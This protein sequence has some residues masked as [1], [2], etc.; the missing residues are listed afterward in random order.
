MLALS[1]SNELKQKVAGLPTEA[2]ISP[3]AD[4]LRRP[5]HWLF[6]FFSFA[7]W[8]AI[9]IGLVLLA[10]EREAPLPI[11]IGMLVQLL[12]TALVPGRELARLGGPPVEEPEAKKAR[13]ALA[14][15]LVDEIAV[16]VLIVAAL[17][18]LLVLHARSQQR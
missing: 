6:A 13:Q 11:A 3:D 1:D 8:V 9:G 16:R 7:S 2:A 18:V 17:A 14:L 12:F 10:R 4:S 15:A 5:S